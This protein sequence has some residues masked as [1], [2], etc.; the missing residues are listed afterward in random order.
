MIT[1]SESL[2]KRL[3]IRNMVLNSDNLVLQHKYKL[4]FV[5][6]TALFD[7]T[8]QSENEEYNDIIVPKVFTYIQ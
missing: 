6:S 1:R 4:L 8:I 2:D 3:S 7:P 5:F